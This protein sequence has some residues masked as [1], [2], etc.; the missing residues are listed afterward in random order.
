MLR[1]NKPLRDALKISARDA[2]LIETKTVVGNS[3]ISRKHGSLQQALTASTY[4]SSMVPLCEQVGL[5]ID[6][7]AKLE[8][9]SVLWKQGESSSSVRM[10]RELCSRTD[11]DGQ[12]VAVGRAGM[13]AQLVGTLF[14]QTPL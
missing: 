3:I 4:L 5:Q 8:A 12:P 2:F 1:R 9:A 10:L 7:A 6:A 13:L 11:L 14:A